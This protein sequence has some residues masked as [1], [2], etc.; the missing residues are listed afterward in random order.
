MSSQGSWVGKSLPQITADIVLRRKVQFFEQLWR[1][2]DTAGCPDPLKRIAFVI[3]W[4]HGE[5]VVVQVAVPVAIREI[6]LERLAIRRG[7][8]MYSVGHFRC[9]D[10]EKRFRFLKYQ[11]I[12]K[13][14][15]VML[16]G[17]PK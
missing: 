13:E 4:A 2:R 7:R 6:F 1:D 10:R 9:V 12:G 8:L 5:V 14:W 16:L 11:S 17:V 3:V 15:Q